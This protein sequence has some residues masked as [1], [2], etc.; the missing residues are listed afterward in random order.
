MDPDW[1][2]FFPNDKV[3]LQCEIEGGSSSWTFMWIKDS[4]T[5]EKNSVQTITVKHSDSGEYSCRG[6]LSDRQVTTQQSNTFQ[7]NVRGK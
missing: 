3:N 2:E 7:L 4:L 5:S 1:T 6:K